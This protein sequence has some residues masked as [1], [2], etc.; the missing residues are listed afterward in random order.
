MSDRKFPLFL[1]LSGRSVAVF[2]GGNIALRR[3]K[4]LLAFDAQITVTAPQICP[5]LAELSE[6]F[7]NLTL[8]LRGFSSDDLSGQFMV[9]AATDS[10][11]LNHEITVEAKHR[12]IL[13]NNAACRNDN[14]FYFPAIAV[15][16]ELTVGI[17]GTGRDHAAVAESAAKIRK[18]LSE[19]EI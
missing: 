19:G 15:T 1:D 17:C 7:P 8:N 12:G 13:A 14:D 5:E 3:V 2:G 9:L 18:F 6:R 16:E 11:A 10:E 4:T